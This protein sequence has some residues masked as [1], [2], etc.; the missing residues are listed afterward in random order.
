MFGAKVKDPKF[1]YLGQA[2]GLKSNSY[3][4]GTYPKIFA[5][6]RGSNVRIFLGNDSDGKPQHGFFHVEDF[7]CEAK[8]MSGYHLYQE[9]EA[10]Q[11]LAGWYPRKKRSIEKCL[12]ERS[13]SSHISRELV[14]L[15]SNHCDTIE[16]DTVDEIVHVSSFYDYEFEAHRQIFVVTHFL[17]VK[18]FLLNP[19]VPPEKVSE[20]YLFRSDDIILSTLLHFI[21]S[22]LDLYQHASLLHAV[23]LD[24]QQELRRIRHGCQTW[25][26]GRDIAT[27]KSNIFYVPCSFK[28]FCHVACS[29]EKLKSSASYIE[30][31]RTWKVPR[32]FF[33]FIP[34]S[35]IFLLA[36]GRKP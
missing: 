29:E 21:L 20:R 32:A 14:L 12:P 7:Q 36:F 5:V 17:D 34:H 11:L 28:T 6:T 26:Y 9:H 19:I 18:Q 31:S 4:V 24:V 2:F 16:I 13:N 1:D 35:R 15:C 30:A 3:V 27:G 23:D 10:K 25:A 33:L 8:T 22:R